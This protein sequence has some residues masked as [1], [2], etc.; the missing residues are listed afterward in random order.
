MQEAKNEMPELRQR[1]PSCGADGLRRAARTDVNQRQ[2]VKALRKAGASV[3][4]LHT[5]G[6]GVPALLVGIGGW[7]YLIEVKGEHGSLTQDQ[8]KWHEEWRGGI[9]VIVRS[10]VE[11]LW[12]VGLLEGA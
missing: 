6:D 12:A 7:T 5:V 3:Q 8:V 9:P 1:K 4:P 10:E 11:A 2:I